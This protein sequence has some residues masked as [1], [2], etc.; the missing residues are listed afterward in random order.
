MVST[1]PATNT[2]PSPAL[3]ACAAPGA[4]RQQ[5]ARPRPVAVVFARLIGAAQNDVVDA[6]RVDARSLHDRLDGNGRESIGAAAGE[7]PAVLPDGRS[8]CRT[9]VRLAIA[10]TDLYR[11]HS[12]THTV[13]VSV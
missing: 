4:A 10:H 1:P 13:F 8:Q 11:L 9:D 5:R 2:S 3:I 12:A 6:R 7:R